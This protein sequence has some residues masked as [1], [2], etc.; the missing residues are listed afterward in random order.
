[1]NSRSTSAVGLREHL[2]E[3]ARRRRG[4]TSRRSL[5][6]A[7]TSSSCVGQEV[8]PLFQRRKLFQGK[9]ISPCP[10]RAGSSLTPWHRRSWVSRSKGIGSGA[11][12]PARALLAACSYSSISCLRRR[13]LDVRAVLGDE[14]IRRPF[15]TVR[16]T[17][18]ESCS[19]AQCCLGF[20]RPRHGAARRSGAFCAW[21][22]SRHLIADRANRRGVLCPGRTEFIRRCGSRRPPRARSEP[23]HASRFGHGPRDGRRAHTVPRQPAPPWPVL[24]AQLQRPRNA[25]ALPR[26][27]SLA[28]GG[29]ALPRRASISTETAS[30]SSMA[31]S[32]AVPA[33]RRRISWRLWR[34]AASD[35][36]S[37]KLLQRR[38]AAPLQHDRVAE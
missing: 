9:G 21:V 37:A 4:T 30:S 20:W 18:S 5:R 29:A 14:V 17:C 15:R 38:G 3:F 25:S 24:H 28:L 8:V 26:T 7:L 2:Q 10:A 16:A 11:P 27:S 23:P 1:M 31:I 6:A 32:S 33:A 13:Q 12:H 35:S 36:T 19:I 22:S 34:C